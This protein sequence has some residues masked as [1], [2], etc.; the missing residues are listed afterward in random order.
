[1]FYF[2]MHE[3]INNLKPWTRRD[4]GKE[5]ITTNIHRKTNRTLQFCW[6]QCNCWTSDCN[7]PILLP[8]RSL[9]LDPVVYKMCDTNV[10]NKCTKLVLK[11]SLNSLKN[12]FLITPKT[13][14]NLTKYKKK[15]N[16]LILNLKL[17][18]LFYQKLLQLKH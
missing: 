9:P 1:M 2:L 13:R 4:V 18:I 5:R 10:R 15:L 3:Q 17:S 11:N 8:D 16:N 12:I 14:K 6:N 7:I